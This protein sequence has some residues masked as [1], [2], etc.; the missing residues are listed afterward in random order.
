MPLVEWNI[1]RSR[2]EAM[3]LKPPSHAYRAVN[4]ISCCCCDGT[5]PVLPLRVT[6][7]ADKIR[8]VS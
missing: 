7:V 3:R 2:A 1:L 5:T 6:A 8:L 4:S